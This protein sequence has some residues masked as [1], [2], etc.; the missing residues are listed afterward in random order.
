MYV[1]AMCIPK[2]AKNVENAHKFIDFMCSTKIAAVNCKFSSFST[3]RKNVYKILDSNVKNNPIAY[4]TKNAL[5]KCET[6]KFLDEQTEKTIS[7]LWEQV[8]I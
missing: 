8:K 4:P 2:N 6:Q 7:E 1:D 3:T 5:N